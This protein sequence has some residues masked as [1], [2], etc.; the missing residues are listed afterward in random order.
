MDRILS[1]EPAELACDL[2]TC[3]ILMKTTCTKPAKPVA[4]AELRFPRNVDDRLRLPLQVRLRGFTDPRRQSVV[5]GGLN[6]YPASV[7]VARPGQPAP[8]GTCV[9]SFCNAYRIELLHWS[10]GSP[11]ARFQGQGGP[12]GSPMCGSSRASMLARRFSFMLR[13]IS[14]ADAG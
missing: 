1:D 12:S 10:S 11:G 8:F 3:F 4:E 14:R 13:S 7:R 2:R 9:A 5:R 6:E